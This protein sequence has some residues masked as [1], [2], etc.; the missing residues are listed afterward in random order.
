MTQVWLDATKNAI[1]VTKHNGTT[2]IIQ[3]GDSITYTG[4]ELGVKVELFVGGEGP[5]G[6]EYLPFRE[7]GRFATPVFSMRG[8][9]HFIICR[10]TGLSHYGQHIDWDSVLKKK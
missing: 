5:I 10:P 6:M 8:N 7:D 1:V 4:R 3:V 9:P 2:L